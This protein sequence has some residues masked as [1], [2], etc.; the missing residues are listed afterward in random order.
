K[1]EEFHE[2]LKLSYQLATIKTDVELP[3]QLADL[4]IKAADNTRLAELYAECEFRR[5]LAEV[6]DTAPAKKKPQATSTQAD[7]FAA[8][9]ETDST[10]ATNTPAS[11]YFTVLDEAGFNVML[12]QLQDCELAAFDTETTSLD[13]MQAGLV[14]LSV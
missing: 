9:D 4:T 11:N 5:W 8:T 7:M 12:A 3:Y 13:Y 6:L 10:A 1:L 14:G 2:Q